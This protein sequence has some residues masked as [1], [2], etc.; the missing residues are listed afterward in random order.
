MILVTGGAG[1]IGSH[2]CVELIESGYDIVVVDNLCNSDDSVISSIIQI[3]GKYFEF[4][5]LD[6]SDVPGLRRVFEKHPID[7][8]IHLA[9]LK[10]V[11]ESSVKPLLYYQNNLVSTLSLCRVMGEFGCH[12]LVFSSSATVYGPNNPVPY[13]EDM[14]L[15]A[16]NPYGR[17]KIIQEQILT[18]ITSADR[19]WNIALL[20]Y[21]NPIGAHP[22]GLIGENPSGTPNNLMPY[23]CCVAAGKLPFL[24]IFGRNYPTHD[25]TGA[26]DYIHVADLARGHI[27]A[28]DYI[29][30][31]SGILTVNLGRGEGYSVLDVVRSF[32]KVSGISIPLRFVENR[33]G[34]LPAYWADV[35]KA[36]TLLDWRAA[37]SL[38]AMCADSWRF[39]SLHFSYIK[40]FKGKKL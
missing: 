11:G 29:K 7:A 3:T 36:N 40:S 33:P 4:Y 1:F 28:L 22:S 14:P 18:D 5:K 27:K 25:G 24:N 26:R 17:T 8:V 32:E 35:S 12:T 23:I 15:S 2:I 20:R 39:A 37:I 13:T 30:N 19:Y 10:A 21:F 16:S 31:H 9:G 38:D 34:D 6:V